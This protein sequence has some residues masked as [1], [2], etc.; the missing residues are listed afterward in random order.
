[1][2]ISNLHFSQS[3]EQRSFF[4]FECLCGIRGLFCG[5]V[6]CVFS[7]FLSLYS[8]NPVH[9]YPLIHSTTWGFSVCKSIKHPTYIELHTQGHAKKVHESFKASI[10]RGRWVLES[11]FTW[12]WHRWLTFPT[13]KSTHCLLHT[14][15]PSPPT[16]PRMHTAASFTHYATETLW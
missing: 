11:H 7:L 8:L 15:M 3:T 14:P 16:H 13:A 2:P 10:Q 1:M 6:L 12:K 5:V 9:L 4:F